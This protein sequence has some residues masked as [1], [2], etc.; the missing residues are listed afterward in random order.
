[1]TAATDTVYLIWSFEHRKWWGPNESGYV[2]DIVNA[3]RYSRECAEAI[4][5]TQNVSAWPEARA[6]TPKERE[7]LELL[8]NFH[9]SC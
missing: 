9:A 1:M 2:A 6:L 4:C 3:G 8:A 7:A 5:L